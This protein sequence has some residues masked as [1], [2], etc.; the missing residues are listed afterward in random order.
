MKKPGGLIETTG[1]KH[2]RGRACYFA[3]DHTEYDGA[4]EG[5][6]E[7]RRQ[8]AQPVDES[9]G[10]APFVTSLPA[11]TRK[12]TKPFRPQK[13]SVAVM[14]AGSVPANVVKES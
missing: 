5:K 10:K 14:P 9:H 1:P 6:G 7:I 4:D 12:F 3:L 2:L 13:V 11:L 8:Y